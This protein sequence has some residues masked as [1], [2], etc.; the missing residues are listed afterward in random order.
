MIKHVLA[1]IAGL[2]IA[3]PIPALATGWQDV[4]LLK[5]LVRGTGTKVLLQTCTES[6]IFG[7]YEYNPT[8]NV[9][10]L[11]ICSNTVDRA[12]PDAVWETLAHEATHA[13]Q[14]CAG[15]TVIE[16]VFTP[17]MLRELQEFTPHYYRALMTYGSADKRTELEA[18]WMEL[19]H[20][21]FVINTFTKHCYTKD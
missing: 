21:E 20:P 6:G 4:N 18:F 11:V 9:D 12:D 15:G 3:T 16:D 17:R 1:V 19:R 2:A 10:T 13:M 5:E 14:A 8:T 7:Y